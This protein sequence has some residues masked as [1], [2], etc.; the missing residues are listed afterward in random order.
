MSQNYVP[1]SDAQVAQ[2]SNDFDIVADDNDWRN[3]IDAVVFNPQ[4]DA[5][6]AAVVF[7]TGCVADVVP[8]DDFSS[9]IQADGYRN[10]PCGP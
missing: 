8:V 1:P 6:V 7:Y 10:G 9:R 3:P 4:V 2:M 5:I